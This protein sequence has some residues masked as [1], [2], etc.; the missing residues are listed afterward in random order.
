LRSPRRTECSSTT[1]I[2][3]PNTHQ[4]QQTIYLARRNTK[5]TDDT[6]MYEIL[7]STTPQEAADTAANA[8]CKLVPYEQVPSLD[9]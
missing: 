8:K 9:A 5:P 3:I 2:W 6:D 4:L 1:R 7:S